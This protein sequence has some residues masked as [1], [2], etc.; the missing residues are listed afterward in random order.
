MFA[1]DE[2]AKGQVVVKNMKQGKQSTESLNE[3]LPS[4]QAMLANKQE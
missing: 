4:I 1:E 2:M 3:L